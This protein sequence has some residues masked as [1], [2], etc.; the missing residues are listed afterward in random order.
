MRLPLNGS[1]YTPTLPVESKP[2]IL[3]NFTFRLPWGSS[4]SRYSRSILLGQESNTEGVGARR[5]LQPT[6]EEVRRTPENRGS[7]RP[8][9]RCD[10]VAD[11]EVGDQRRD[12]RDGE[13]RVGPLLQPSRCHGHK[14]C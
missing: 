2:H 3:P 5:G 7:C 12:E 6:P 1:S 11:G 10:S 14:Q 4:A 13:A 9:P 8:A